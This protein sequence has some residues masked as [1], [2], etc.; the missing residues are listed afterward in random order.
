MGGAASGEQASHMRGEVE[1]GACS[2]LQ[3]L[4]KV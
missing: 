2:P 4:E 1:G 3:K